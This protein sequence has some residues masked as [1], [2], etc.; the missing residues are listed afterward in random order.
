MYQV[1][2]DLSLIYLD[3]DLLPVSLSWHADQLLLTIFLV[4]IANLVLKIP[5]GA[6]I[7]VLRILQNRA[8][9]LWSALICQQA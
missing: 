7:V 8:R 3:L 4:A 2:S 1:V 5:V 6:N 9:I